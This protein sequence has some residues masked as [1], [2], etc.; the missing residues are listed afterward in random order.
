MSFSRSIRRN[1]VGC[2]TAAPMSFAAWDLIYLQYFLPFLSAQSRSSSA[3]PT[4]APGLY[5][6]LI[7]VIS[8]MW[9]TIFWDFGKIA[10]KH[11]ACEDGSVI[12]SKPSQSRNASAPICVTFSG[13]VILDSPLHPANAESPILVRLLGSMIRFSSLHQAN[14][15][16]PMLVTPSG[17]V[18]SVMLRRP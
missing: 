13:I 7:P 9:I 6:V 3:K 11:L 15:K 4:A 18:M 5:L 2:S 14:A 12:S 16:F 8:S 10:N 17:I 1:S